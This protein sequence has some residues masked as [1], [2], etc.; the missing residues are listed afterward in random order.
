M[1]RPASLLL[2]A[3]L[4]LAAQTAS[5]K[6]ATATRHTATSAAAKTGTS[7]VTTKADN[8][9]GVPPV[10]TAPK[11]LY[12]L[13]YVDIV[14]GTGPLAAP[15]KFYTVKYTGW[16]TDGT[17]FDSS[18]DHPG[19]EPITFA[20]GAHRVI[21]GWD[22]GFTG[23]RIGGKRRLYIPYQ[24][25]YGENG[26]EGAIPPK[27]D[28]IFDIELV[29]FADAPPAPAPTPAEPAQNPTQPQP[30]TAAPQPNSTS[31]A[32]PDAPS[33]QKASPNPK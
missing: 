31:A 25:A 33:P 27:A 5:H 22:T 20:Y 8:P 7:S 14:T 13:R 9:P 29:N 30:N 18:F 32:P 19:Q 2:L 6:P 23:M 4:P 26:R 10:T 11:A 17:K 28:L 16:L 21:P 15:N 1:I 12:A 24:L 3:S